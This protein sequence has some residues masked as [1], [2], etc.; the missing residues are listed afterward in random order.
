VLLFCLM[1]NTLWLATRWSVSLLSARRWAPTKQTKL[2]MSIYH[3]HASYICL[4]I[5]FQFSVCRYYII[6]FA[7]N[8]SHGNIRSY[9][10]NTTRSWSI[11]RSLLSHS[12]RL[13][14]LGTINLHTWPAFSS[15]KVGNADHSLC[16]Y[17]LFIWLS[18][19]NILCSVRIQ[20]PV[21]KLGLSIRPW[22]ALL[23]RF[24]FR[25]NLVMKYV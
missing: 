21:V 5:I 24:W 11:D 17:L 22:P 13:L 18:T 16:T 8:V 14:A 23:R 10:L 1:V 4:C 20:W 6:Y 19:F 12:F 15:T 9:V 7:H 2:F 25:C 3:K